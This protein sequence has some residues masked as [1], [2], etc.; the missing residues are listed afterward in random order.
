M[1]QDIFNDLFIVRNKSMSF[2]VSENETISGSRIGGNEPIFFSEQRIRELNLT[3]HL[4]FMTISNDLIKE[5]DTEFSV[6][7]PKK[8]EDTLYPKHNILCIAHPF[9]NRKEGISSF[10][11]SNIV[12]RKL[13]IG[14]LQED[15]EEIEDEE[16]EESFF[17]NV[18]GNKIGG[19]PSLLQEE[20]YYFSNLK[21]NNFDFI[22]QFDES[23][24]Q[25]GQVIGNRP[26]L[27]GIIYFYGKID[28]NRISNIIVG[29]WQKG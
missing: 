16:E 22:F 18:Y 13:V 7:I 15:I 28:N 1:T 24:Y 8:I 14:N 5:I 20:D 6:F 27:N 23:L 11:N 12:G 4:Y 9:S 10:S 17:E 3:N 2:Q 19:N 26:F 25:K 21:T 29:F